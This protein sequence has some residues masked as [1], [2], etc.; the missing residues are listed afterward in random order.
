MQGVPSACLFSLA[1]F[2]K[3]LSGQAIRSYSGLT[4]AYPARDINVLRSRMA[5]YGTA[6]ME[7]GVLKDLPQGS[8]QVY[9]ALA[10]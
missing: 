2:S 7:E 6:K 8:G 3:A 9:R 4:S 1:H 10:D 5:S